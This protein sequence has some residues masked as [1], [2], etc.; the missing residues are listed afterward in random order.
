[1]KNEQ[2]ITLKLKSL[3]TLQSFFAGM[4]NNVFKE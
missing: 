3:K 4:L 2:N 1:M